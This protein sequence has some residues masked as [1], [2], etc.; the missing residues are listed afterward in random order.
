[1]LARLA[2]GLGRPLT[3]PANRGGPA[4]SCRAALRKQAARLAGML[5]AA[6]SCA[7]A[8]SPCPTPE[9]IGVILRA[10]DHLN[11]GDDGES[12][13]TTVRLY[14]LRDVSKLA[15]ASLEQVLD[16]DRAVL[17]EDLVSVKEITLYPGEAARP[18]LSRRE[19]AAFLALV[20][21]FRQP[22]GSAWRVAGKLAPPDPLYCHAAAE[23][24]ARQ[25]A[26]R[27][28]LVENHVD[29]Q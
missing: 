20:V 10:A 21:F 9:P 2:W 11:P 16:N 3:N 28:A 7:H 29:L 4:V 14:Q 6:A 18:S 24:E 15:A 1:M 17:G 25:P 27:F 5:A 8:P 13:A 19:G 23:G 22:E 26:F 12:L